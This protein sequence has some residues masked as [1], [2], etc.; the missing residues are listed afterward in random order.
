MKK[1]NPG[2]TGCRASADGGGGG[3]T[4]S[5][6]TV[7]KIII[8]INQGYTAPEPALLFEFAQHEFARNGTCIDLQYKNAAMKFYSANDSAVNQM[9]N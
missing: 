9:T 5:K 8:I 2:V 3:E 4:G 1:A 7:K 6:E